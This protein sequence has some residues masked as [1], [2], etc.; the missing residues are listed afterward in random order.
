MAVLVVAAVL[1]KMAFINQKRVG[2]EEDP[3]CTF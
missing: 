3:W 1:N 2:E